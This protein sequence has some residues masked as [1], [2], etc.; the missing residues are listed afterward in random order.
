M[1]EEYFDFP[2]FP[3]FVTAER[4]DIL[5]FLSWSSY[6]RYHRTCK[7]PLEKRK[8]KESIEIRFRIILLFHN[9][10]MNDISEAFEAAC[11]CTCSYN[12]SSTFWFPVTCTNSMWNLLHRFRLRRVHRC[13]VY[14]SVRQLQFHHSHLIPE[15]IFLFIQITDVNIVTVQ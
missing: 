11:T 1:R 5:H 12:F 14:S 13:S 6:S 7:K 15:L 2:S 9:N 3:L 8:R 10:A 4:S